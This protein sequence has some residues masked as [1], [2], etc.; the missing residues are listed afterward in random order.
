MLLLVDECLSRTLLNTLRERGN[1]V[2]FLRDETTGISD[3]EVMATA[4]ADDRLVVTEDRDFGLLTFRDRLPSRGVVVFAVSE[5][6]WSTTRLAVHVAEIL[7]E[8]GETCIG[9]LTTIEPGRVR[10]RRLEA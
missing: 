9:S 4:T 10:Q 7:G 2:R 6:G 8:I 1:D 5:F 3:S